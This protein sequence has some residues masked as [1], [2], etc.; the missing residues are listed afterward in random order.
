[1]IN[2]QVSVAPAVSGPSL[3]TVRTNP[4]TGPVEFL[5]AGSEV[6]DVIEIFDIGG[7]RVEVLAIPAGNRTL[8]WRWSQ[9]GARPG[10][11]LARLRS[12]G[13]LV[14]FSVVR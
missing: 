7:R 11:Y 3:F 9:A 8:S 2:I 14:R 12:R 1:M 10:V 6:A 4:S 13:E 5:I